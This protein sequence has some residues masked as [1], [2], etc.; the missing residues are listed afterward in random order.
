MFP[1]GFWVGSQ[2]AFPAPQLVFHDLGERAA[3]RLELPQVGVNKRGIGSG[4]QYQYWTN[5]CQ[6]DPYDLL[7]KKNKKISNK[8]IK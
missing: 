8:I 2:V 4:C 5:C 6:V 1:W 7:H 3:L